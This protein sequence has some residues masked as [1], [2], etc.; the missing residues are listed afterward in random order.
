MTDS[1]SSD[2]EQLAAMVALTFASFLSRIKA[3][4]RPTLGGSFQI[5]KAPNR[6]Y[7]A[8]YDPDLLLFCELVF[9]RRYRVQM[10]L[11]S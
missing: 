5:G 3:N 11:V 10:R 1:E 7:F 4:Q 8:R 9:E 6:Y 2:E